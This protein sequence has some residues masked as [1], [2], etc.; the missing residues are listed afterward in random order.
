MHVYS[1]DR[2]LRSA[3]RLIQPQYADRRIGAQELSGVS[4]A[5]GVHI[6]HYGR[7]ALRERRIVSPGNS[8]GA[9][10]EVT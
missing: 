5:H 4:V 7:R 1:D 8:L 6:S 9:D 2:R 10:D 3:T